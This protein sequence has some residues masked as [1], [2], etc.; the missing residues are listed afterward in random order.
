[1]EVSGKYIGGGLFRGLHE[2]RGRV[3]GFSGIPLSCYLRKCAQCFSGKS[4]Q[5]KS[6]TLANL[7]S[8]LK[9]AIN[10]ATRLFLVVLFVSGFTSSYLVDLRFK[11]HPRDASTV[12]LKSRPPNPAIVFVRTDEDRVIPFSTPCRPFESPNPHRAPQPPLARNAPT[13]R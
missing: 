4:M 6:S 8:R 12:D 10:P 3:F 9:L 2:R 7:L 5:L 13:I 11:T 1:V